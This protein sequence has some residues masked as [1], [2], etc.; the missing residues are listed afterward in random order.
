[1]PGAAEPA[2][3]S[4]L[5]RRPGARTGAA[6]RLRSA[7]PER[8][9][10][11][12][13]PRIASAA[14]PERRRNRAAGQAEPLP[15]RGAAT[16]RSACRRRRERRRRDAP[17]FVGLAGPAPR[18]AQPAG[19]ARPDGERHADVVRRHD[20]RARVPA[21]VPQHREAG[22]RAARTR[23]DRRSRS[24]SGSRRRSSAWSASPAPATTPPH[25][26]VEEDDAPGDDAE[27]L[28]RVQEML[29][30]QPVDGA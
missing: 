13:A 28:R 7:R 4:R 15:S 18:A 11:A 17:P 25:R 22:A 12:A 29:G 27:A 5:R 2:A 20:A 6:R 23:C 9:A 24:C 3:R 21:D 30:A 14:A 19:A 26:V 8:D 10:E 16:A 1:M